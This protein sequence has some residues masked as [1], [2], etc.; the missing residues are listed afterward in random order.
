MDRVKKIYVKRSDE[1]A[2]IAEQIIDAAAD[3]IVVNVPKFSRIADSAG[4]FHLLKREADVL[5]KKIIVESVD[6]VV[7]EL[8]KKS[9]IDSLNPFFSRGTRQISDIVVQ[10]RGERQKA[11]PA[12]VPP[13]RP[14]SDAP[15]GKKE[16]R[17]QQ[18]EPEENIA[19]YERKERHESRE[20][21]IPRRGLALFRR[22]RVV[23]AAA[24]LLIGAAL[25]FAF[26][27][28]PR[29]E[30]RLVMERST[31]EYKNAVSADTAL[32]A[33]NAEAA[34]IPA[35]LFTK[36]QNVELSFP[37]TGK[38]N[39]MKR[40]SGKVTI[41]NAYS[42]AP[43]RLVANTRI[44]APDGKIFRL[45]QS[46]TVPG[47][48][49]AGGRIEP[50]SIEAAVVAN[51][52][53]EA[54]NIGPVPRFTIPGFQD[55]PKFSGFYAESKSPMT[56]GAVGEMSFP[57][58]EDIRKAKATVQEKLETAN[59][60]YFLATLPK[61]LKMLDGAMQFRAVSQTVRPEADAEGKFSVFEEGETTLIAFQESDLLAM[62]LE[63]AKRDLGA[64]VVMKDYRLAYGNPQPE[65][66]GGTL[67]IPLEYK[68]TFTKSVDAENMRRQILGLKERDLKA[69]L[70]TLAGL[71]RAQVSLWPFWVRSVPKDAEKVNVIVE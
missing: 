68:G 70:L 35:Q 41:Y 16:G 50:S 4:N 23:G 38:K 34:K 43:Q 57:T 17:S 7:I 44:A 30:I 31:M 27:A 26:T 37:A 39:V 5:G 6:D 10:R 11:R 66:K 51:E 45:A 69:R 33:I 12:A 62:F 9:G 60:A 19:R 63:R 49:V 21:R 1:A 53:G 65:V 28:M 18:P 71:D 32:T 8:C 58:D 29:A 24:I 2:A 15:K 22:R 46:V 14:S 59:K 42:S 3:E 54:F 55:S 25:F 67:I 61:Q 56:G 47:A 20:G 13:E 48:K 36:V 64:S 40:A 52:P